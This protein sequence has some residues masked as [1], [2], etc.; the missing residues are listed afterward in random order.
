MATANPT[1][2][3]ER[4]D[5]I[6]SRALSVL[7]HRFAE[8]GERYLLNAPSAVH[9][10][11][12][13]RLAELDHEVF[14]AAFLDI[15]HRVIAL[16]QLFQGTLTQT[17]VYPREIARAALRLNAAAVVLIHNHPSG[18]AEFSE[19]DKALT[20][21]IRSALRLIDV[22]VLDHVLI[23]GSRMASLESIEAAQEA[24]AKI[25]KA[26]ALEEVRAVRSA[27]LKAAWQ[28]R[29]AKAADQ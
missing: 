1:T 6:I 10:Y 3:R 4:E 22:H 11:A 26:R 5:R 28:R 23:A 18:K 27:A 16:E 8:P 15:Q 17:T 7:E 14:A 9:A 19:E 13:L 24:K 29:R 12:R 25:V 21:G 20:K 2:Q